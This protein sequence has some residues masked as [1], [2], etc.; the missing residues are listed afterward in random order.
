MDTYMFIII[1]CLVII[2]SFIFDMFSD[3][4]SVPSVLLLTILGVILNQVFDLSAYNSSYMPILEM[5][6]TIG[7]IIIVLE[8]A[9]DLKIAQ[10]KKKVIFQSLAISFI[11][12]NITSFGIAA[13]FMI[14]V[15]G[16]DMATALLYAI[17]FSIMSSAV[18]IPSVSKLVQTKKEFMIYE[19]AFSDIFGI[20][21]FYILLENIDTD[22]FF[23]IVG[24]VVINLSLTVI[25]SL[26]GSFVLLYVFQKLVKIKTRFF[27]F[28]SLLV[29]L[30]VTGKSFHLSSLLI[31]LVFG[32]VL[33][34]QFFFVIQPLKKY[35]DHLAID[36]L[37]DSFKMITEES[38]FII[39]TFF[40][41]LFGLAIEMDS[42]LRRD[43]LI[44]S[45]ILI[46]SFYVIRYA[47]FRSIVGKDIFPEV[48]LAP[49][50]LISI[51]LFFAIPKE[52]HVP[53]IESGTLFVVVMVTCLIMGGAL[54]KWRKQGV[55]IKNEE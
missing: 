52:F 36:S 39:R 7:L 55:G 35:Y 51:L 15:Q 3:K 32:I 5:L 10:E 13:L 53:E 31:I 18:V 21:A 44:F 17:P 24:N 23:R 2:I 41:V 48:F 45:A 8:A 26:V 46:A 50:G 54:F 33:K 1:V 49:R 42:V 40:F 9:L 34:N 37:F 30:Y 38:A 22:G 29:L 12:L 19:S 4:T 43:V 6:G 28:L 25:I 20:M 14:S 47:L 11:S 16:I 27:L